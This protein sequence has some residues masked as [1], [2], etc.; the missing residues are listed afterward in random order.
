MSYSPILHGHS[1]FV[2]ETDASTHDWAVL[3]FSKRQNRGAL[4][5]VR[6]KNRKSYHVLELQAVFFVLRALCSDTKNIHIRLMMDSITAVSYVREQGGS[7]STACNEVARKLWLWAYNRQIWISSEHFVGAL[8]VTTDFESR[9]FQKET[10]W[11]LDKSVFWKINSKLGF[12]PDT[13]LFASRVN[14]QLPIV[15]WNPHPGYF[16]VNAFSLNWQILKPY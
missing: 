3:Q 14:F 10:E 13:D 15:S 16:A 5:G 7:K 4:G 8:N 1:D 12:E 11:M 9:N 2:S 6:N